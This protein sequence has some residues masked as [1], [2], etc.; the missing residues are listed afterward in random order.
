MCLN[1]ANCKTESKDKNKNRL[2][3]NECMLGQLDGIG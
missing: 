1:E 3:L 2:N